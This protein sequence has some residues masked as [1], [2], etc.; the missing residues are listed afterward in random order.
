MTAPS[1][2]QN[3]CQNCPIRH[4][5]VCSRCDADELKM[6]ESIK[7][8]RNFSAGETIF[9][10]GEPMDF[11]ASVVTGVAALSKTLEDGRTQMVGLLLPSDFMGRPGRAHVEFDVTATTDVTL[12]C[13]ERLPFEKLTRE[14]PHITQRLMELVLDEL[15]A[16]R[17]WML[18]LGRKTAREKI[19]T[20]IEMLSR[21]VRIEKG[22]Q[23]LVLPM[24]MTRDQIANFLG[25]TL[26][27]VSRQFNALKKEGIIEFNDRK[28]I[29][30]KDIDALQDAT[31]DDVEID[32]SI[33]A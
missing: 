33:V 8:Y 14:N 13:F 23:T 21:R 32:T 20:F 12:C 22:Q 16:A 27:T 19:A 2:R 18:L 3:K 28:H 5:A 4:R 31:G 9:W 30:I 11:L 24:S 1:F 29:V 7:T 10:R 17:D 25:L 15:D 6:L 26:E